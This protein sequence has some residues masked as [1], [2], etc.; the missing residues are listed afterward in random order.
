MLSQCQQN[1]LFTTSVIYP[2]V[3]LF[4]ATEHK[5]FAAVLRGVSLRFL[6]HFTSPH[7]IRL[8][9]LAEQY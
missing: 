7:D 2:E 5:F 6:G 9:I 8:H 3:L 1:N 4:V